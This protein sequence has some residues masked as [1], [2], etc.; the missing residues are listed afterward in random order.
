M[1]GSPRRRSRGSDSSTPFPNRTEA[2]APPAD[3]APQ[4]LSRGVT[5][6]RIFGSAGR[7]AWTDERDIGILVEFD[8]LVGAFE[9]LDLWDELARVGGCSADLVIPVAT[10][11]R[12]RARIERGAVDAV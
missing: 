3:L 10:E 8:R 2:F 1:D 4:L 7:D 11:E 12:M 9:C 5:S 6:L